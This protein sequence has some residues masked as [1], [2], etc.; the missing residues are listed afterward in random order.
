MWILGRPTGNL[1]YSLL[2]FI[3]ALTFYLFWC[4]HH[5]NPLHFHAFLLKLELIQHHW[6]SN[7]P[8]VSVNV[9]RI[10]SAFAIIINIQLTELRVDWSFFLGW[11]VF[12]SLIGFLETGDVCSFLIFL[13][14]SKADSNFLFFGVKPLNKSQFKSNQQDHL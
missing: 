6:W 12:F 9:S 8:P 11:I 7:L 2:S 4:K 1:D 14:L 13:G 5:H 10:K 3:A